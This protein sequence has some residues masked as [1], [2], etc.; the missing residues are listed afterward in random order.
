M[1]HLRHSIM[2]PEALHRRLKVEAS[3]QGLHIREVTEQILDAWLRAQRGSAK[4][5]VGKGAQEGSS[6]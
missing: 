3:R 5:T 2:I 6:K 4:K 1:D